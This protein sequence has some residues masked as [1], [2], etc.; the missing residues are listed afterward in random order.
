MYFVKARKNLDDQD[1]GDSQEKGRRDRYQRSDSARLVLQ[2]MP[3]Q[4]LKQANES[5]SQFHRSDSGAQGFGSEADPS[6]L[7]F[8]PEELPDGACYRP[9]KD[10]TNLPSAS[11]AGSAAVSVG[12]SQDIQNSNTGLM[13][14][15]RAV[16]VSFNA[17]PVYARGSVF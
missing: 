14:H 1:A 6:N 2:A 15:I 13:E 12:E 3:T 10:L 11:L 9:K 7:E 16:E 8:R 5:K 17:V 4:Q